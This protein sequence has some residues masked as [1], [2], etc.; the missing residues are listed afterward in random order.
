[1]NNV[2]LL[3]LCTGNSCRSQMAEG[4]ARRLLSGS[5]ETYS[6]GTEPKGMDPLAI[7]VM[8][9]AGVDISG[10]R[11][12]HI[13]ELQQHEF[14]I[15]ITLCGDANDNCP[16]FASGARVMHFGFEDPPKLA[17]GA[18]D[19]EEALVHYRRVRDE[20]RRFV[21]DLPEI[22]KDINKGL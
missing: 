8:L 21:S 2:K 15:V 14:N 20:I 3:F 7:K 5:I 17:A 22:L 18:A 19:E 6:A 13:D 10:Q 16:I 12:K 11:S 1:M 4:W 9:E